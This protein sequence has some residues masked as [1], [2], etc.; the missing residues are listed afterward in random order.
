MEEN[1]NHV[2]EYVDTVVPATCTE[3]GYTLHRCECGHEYKDKFVG[4][5]KHKFE[6]IAETE[7]G[8]ITEGKRELRCE[9]CG[10][11]DSEIVRAT[12]H[13][14]AHWNIET[15]PTCTEEGHRF[16]YCKTCGEKEEQ[17]I[18][19]KGHKLTN[20]QKSETEKGVKIYFCT[21]CGASVRKESFFRR[22][23]VKLIA[24]AVIAGVVALVAAGLYI[25]FGII[26]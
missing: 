22:N 12:G 7:P 5:R 15:A 13:K 23:K 16:R 21:N 25:Y 1:T 8:C 20:P 11:T 14:W 24:A 18:K 19:P 4:L 3:Q 17:K 2:H 9:V 26:A 10:A 6:V